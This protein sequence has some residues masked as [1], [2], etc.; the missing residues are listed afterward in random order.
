MAKEEIN[1]KWQDFMAPY[2]ENLSGAHA[3]ES[4]VELAEVF[5]WTSILSGIPHAVRG[6]Q[7]KDAE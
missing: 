7:S 4:M 1:A 3:D 6:M 2:F 5:I